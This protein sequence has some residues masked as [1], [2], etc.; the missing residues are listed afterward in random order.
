MSRI[1]ILVLWCFAAGLFASTLALAAQTPETL[2][3]ARGLLEHGEVTEASHIVETLLQRHSDNADGWALL[4]VIRVQ[5]NEP[6][7]AEESFRKALAIQPNL[8]SAQTN[9]GHLLLEEHRQAE[10]LPYL[11]DALRRDNGNSE[12]R[13]MLVSAAEGTALK[14]RASGDRDGALA[15]LLSAKAEV[16][17]SFAL[18]LDLSILE[19]ELR[20]LRDADRDVREARSIHPEDLKALYAEA[21][22]KMDLQ[23]MPEAER[24]LRAYLKTRPEDATA[25]YGLGRILQMTQ[26]S[27]EA[28]AE[29]ERSIA[30]VP[31]QAESYYQIGQM[32]LDHGNYTEAQQECRKAL[33]HDPK[34]GGALTA[35]GIA[36]FRL[37]QYPDAVRSLEA[38]IAVAPEYQPAHYYYGLALAR[39]GQKEASE[40]ELKIAAQMADEQN[41]REAQRLQLVP[42]AASA[43]RP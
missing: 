34:H 17:H 23:D 18:L 13:E 29:F 30:V 43:P 3:R 27:D 39:N 21:R 26:R 1:S 14:Q 42:G 9:L 38:A 20:L 2:Q 35:V 36:A 7:K 10:A 5:Q 37:K 40:R 19:D 32:A 15:T 16:P 33:E 24:D 11:T 8:T 31:N 28:K 12:L 22:V 4:G 25:H 6:A 41:R